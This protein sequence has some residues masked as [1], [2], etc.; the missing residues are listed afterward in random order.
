MSKPLFPDSVAE[1]IVKA[2][3]FGNLLYLKFTNLALPKA[4]EL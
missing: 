4:G 3:D 1:M 2:D